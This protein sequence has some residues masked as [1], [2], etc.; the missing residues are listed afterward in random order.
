MVAPSSLAMTQLPDDGDAQVALAPLQTSLGMS[1]QM[2]SLQA[3]QGLGQ[4]VAQG[5]QGMQ[6]VSGAQ[7]AQVSQSVHSGQGF[8]RGS[9]Q[10]D[11]LPSSSNIGLPMGPMGMQNY[12]FTSQQMS[13]PMNHISGLNIMS[14]MQLQALAAGNKGPAGPYSPQG[15]PGP[16]NL[17]ASMNTMPLAGGRNPKEHSN[18]PPLQGLS[19]QAMQPLNQSNVS[20]QQLQLQGLQSMPQLTVQ[21]LQQLHN[22]QMTANA[23][24]SQM[25]LTGA[26]SPPAHMGSQQFPYGMQAQLAPSS[27]GMMVGQNVA[28]MGSQGRLMHT[29]GQPQGGAGAGQLGAQA[30]I[31]LAPSQSQSTLM[32]QGTMGSRGEQVAGVMHAPMQKQNAYY[33]NVH[34]LQMPLM[35]SPPPYN[36]GQMRVDDEEEDDE[37]KPA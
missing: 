9:S 21:N 19:M 11:P 25:R 22:I 34:P 6:G 1:G 12:P 13:A 31:S 16:L 33:P 37:M 20:L 17:N 30:M 35:Q 10:V 36:G 23:M 27:G 29:P 4:P 18:S 32:K 28:L 3:L 14:P 5:M 8:H 15:P 24:G 7:M 26:S 2:A